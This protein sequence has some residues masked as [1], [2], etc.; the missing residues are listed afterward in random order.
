MPMTVNAKP[1]AGVAFVTGGASGIG[2]A[3]ALALCN[4]GDDVGVFD[5]SE[6]GAQAV[7]RL[8]ESRGGRA[9]AIGGDVSSDADVRLAVDET[10]HRFGR[11]TTVVANAGVAHEGTALTTSDDDWNRV[12][13]VILT[14]T[15]LTARHTIPELTATGGSFVAVASE[16][17]INGNQRSLAY[18]AAKHGVI[19]LMRNMALDHGPQGVRTNAVCPGWVETPM[20]DQYFRGMTADEI[21]E[22]RRANPLGR[23]ATPEIVA[24]VILH[25]SSPDA[26]HTNGLAYVVDG[27]VVTGTFD[28]SVA[29]P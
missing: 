10:V 7:V 14:G 26:R 13:A 25:L 29:M 4:R 28:P 21:A 17:G 16:A 3:T 22:L 19:G 1:S 20:M 11:L 6:E 18:G 24:D 8:I 23:F 27:G 9:V 2:R 12:I 5:R 15:F